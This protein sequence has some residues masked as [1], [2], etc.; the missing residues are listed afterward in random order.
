MTP[1]THGGRAAKK[2]PTQVK[3]EPEAGSFTIETAA[4]TPDGPS[5]ATVTQFED[6]Q[7]GGSAAHATALVQ[8]RGLHHRDV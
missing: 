2:R 4:A 5:E 7:V 8:R 6:L 1:I 3:T